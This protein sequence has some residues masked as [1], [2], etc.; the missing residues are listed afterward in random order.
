[1]LNPGPWNFPSDADKSTQSHWIA[2]G[3]FESRPLQVRAASGVA[4]HFGPALTRRL[5][6]N[7]FGFEVGNFH[8]R[9]KPGSSSCQL[10]NG[11]LV[12]MTRLLGIARVESIRK[13]ADKNATL[14]TG[15]R[16]LRTIP[17]IRRRDNS[18]GASRP[19]TADNERDSGPGSWRSD[20]LCEACLQP[21]TLGVEPS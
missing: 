17:T 11:H 6:S 2:I 10:V 14:T 21:P 4:P 13:C 5:N 20:S 15:S 3:L 9:R 19:E 18:A 16:E 1:M 8:G 12:F 7:S